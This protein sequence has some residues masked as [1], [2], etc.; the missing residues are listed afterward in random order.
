MRH[1]IRFPPILPVF[2]LHL[3]LACAWVP[4]SPQ[5]PPAF[6][7]E[8]IGP[9]SVTFG[10]KAGDNPLKGFVDPKAVGYNDLTATRPFNAAEKE[11]IKFALNYWAERLV[12]HPGNGS[13]D[14]YLGFHNNPD[15]SA[16]ASSPLSYPPY[17]N[18][19][20]GVSPNGTIY[21]NLVQ[22]R[23]SPWPEGLA[24]SIIIFEVP[25]APNPVRQLM[26]DGGAF[27]TVL[28][29]MGHSLGI[30]THGLANDNDDNTG[31]FDPKGIGAWDQHLRDVYGKPALPGMK[32]ANNATGA[33]N[34]PGLFQY[35]SSTG[36]S[37][38]ARYRYPTF[39]G[40]EVDALSGGAGMPV[41]GGSPWT[42][43]GDGIDGGNSLGHPGIM[44]SIMSY[45]IVRNMAF[46]EME[47]AMF[48]DLGYKIDLG[49]FFGK[50]FYNNV[51]GNSQ[52]NSLG[53]GTAAN[54]NTAILGLGV[55]VMRDNLNLTQAADLH[56]N[57]HGGG[58]I[59]LDGS[60][61]RLVIPAGVAVAADGQNGTGLLVSFGKNNSLDLQGV[62]QAKGDG[63]IAA[64]LGIGAADPRVAS[65]MPDYSG[66]RTRTDSDGAAK[67]V[68]MQERHELLLSHQTL[69]AALVKDFNISGTLQGKQ[70][71][72]QIEADSHVE[73]LNFYAGATVSGHIASAWARNSQG[74]SDYRTLLT[75]GQAGDGGV[76]QLDGNITWTKSDQY[77]TG[78]KAAVVNSL[79]VDMADGTLVFNGNANV[80]S[81]TTQKT[82]TLKGNNRIKIEGPKEF[83]S[84]GTISPGGEDGTGS[85]TID[86]DFLLTE[87]GVLD[88][89]IA[90]GQTDR[91]LVTGS[92]TLNGSV[93]L[94]PI[95]TYYA[96]N[97]GL[98]I[99]PEML[100]GDNVGLNSVDVFSNMNLST[101]SPTLQGDVNAN[102]DNTAAV[103][104]FAR[105]PDSYSQYALG[106]NSANLGRALYRVADHA[107]GEMPDL[108]VAL[109]FSAP[110]GSEVR[111]G[112]TEL[113][114]GSYA[115]EVSASWDDGRALAGA[116]FG[117]LWS[118]A[119]T[120]RRLASAADP[121]TCATV[122]ENAPCGG[123]T[124]DGRGR[125]F[126]LPN[127]GV[128]RQKTRGDAL[129]YD[130]TRVGA[131]AGVNWL[132]PHGIFGIHASYAHRWTDTDT[133]AQSRAGSDVFNLGLQ[134]LWQPDNGV[135]LT[136][137]ADAGLELTR[138]D[139]SAAVGAF[140]R[141]YEDNFTA[142]TLMGAFRTGYEWEAGC[143]RWGPAAG[144]DYNGYFRPRV[145]ETGG[146]GALQLDR[147]GMHSLQLAA[148]LQ[149]RVEAFTEGGNRVTAQVGADWRHEF[150]PGGNSYQ[151][152]FI[153]YPRQ[154]FAGEV[155][156]GGRDSL[157]LRAGAALAV[158]ER[159]E[160]GAYAG[161]EFF[162]AGYNS[163][164]GG[165]TFSCG[166]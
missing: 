2:F 125:F 19:K 13:V 100:F 57:G 162:R 133:T 14:V 110:D 84:A 109:D 147:E 17:D 51:G 26:Y 42:D 62:L 66:A 59:R 46:S 103:F 164:Q 117:Q 55:H 137:L 47:L 90:P 73:H 15:G 163:I 61:N 22:N 115:N 64:H 150:L 60:G 145:E 50:S 34:T 54:P 35:Y 155:R 113:L 149:A 74:G 91:F 6:S 128:A 118:M 45:G 124:P 9:Y 75:F 23:A 80:Y 146:A 93:N 58:G 28:H 107:Q 134:G 106:D 157:A 126:L 159:F 166:F 27:A 99:T 49:D 116:V 141:R 7:G 94:T 72:I 143:W 29:E 121:S 165:L 160:V 11:Q 139:R 24:D 3:C 112:L 108:F 89:Q 138:M 53:F 132:L 48:N 10:D 140:A 33:N 43:S 69:N 21:D 152:A 130:S 83:V 32:I 1:G 81:W 63:G 154:G 82:A 142:F 156:R 102:A 129:G 36:I 31:Y 52:T 65:Y 153:G 20:W 44:G 78:S 158:R 98:E 135:F 105:T 25:Y 41:M 85:I 18:G 68:P 8:R 136:V 79:D 39:H 96:N 86:G 76:M 92:A 123:E 40:P 127:A 111:A 5:F 12:N 30:G 144:L 37:D 95:S 131:V 16:F 70:A 87:T 97:A 4:L 114:P 151:A 38:P 77:V 88:L 161:A 56:A 119:A 101:R 104:T 122:G 148:G 67:A 120:T 71:A